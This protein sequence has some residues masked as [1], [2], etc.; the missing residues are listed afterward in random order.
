MTQEFLAGTIDHTLLKPHAD[1][2]QIV[3][4][5]KGLSSTNL[6]RGCFSCESLFPVLLDPLVS[7][8]KT[9]AIIWTIHSLLNTRVNCQASIRIS[10]C[11]NASS[12]FGWSKAFASHNVNTLI[13]FS[14]V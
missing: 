5:F 2:H 6:F 4:L 3:Q 12:L 1:S 14:Y 9:N 7:L 11:C 10:N 8:L 13:A